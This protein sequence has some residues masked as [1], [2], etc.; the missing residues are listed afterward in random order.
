MRLFKILSIT[1]LLS[2]CLAPNVQAGK[3]T[4]AKVLKNKLYKS[5]VQISQEKKYPLVMHNIQTRL[6][7]PYS[8][9]N[10]LNIVMFWLRD[11]YLYDNGDPKFGLSYVQFLESLSRSMKQSDPEQSQQLKMN[12]MIHY[13]VAEYFLKSDLARCADQSAGANTRQE[14]DK[15]RQ[16]HLRAFSA[17]RQ[18]DKE[19]TYK[20]IFT[21]LD[22]S[23]NRTSYTEICKS[24]VVHMQKVLESGQYQEDLNTENGE[25]YIDDDIAAQVIDETS[26]KKQDNAL[27]NMLQ[28]ELLALQ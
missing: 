27:Y 3:D 8:S 16:N 19:H 11:H 14:M 5:L 1:L 28:N 6:K 23:V 18:E 21:M 26:R 12:S 22:E 10:D 20:T 15:L 4:P 2:F 17:L 25:T 24:G 13:F 9:R 7:A